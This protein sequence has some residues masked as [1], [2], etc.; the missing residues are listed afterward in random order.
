MMKA[1]ELKKNRVLRCQNRLFVPN[2]DELRKRILIEAH[3]L[4]YSIYPGSTK[5]YNDLKEMY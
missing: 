4:R 1:F 5:M 2:I 3:N